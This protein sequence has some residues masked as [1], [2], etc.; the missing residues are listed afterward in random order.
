VLAAHFNRRADGKQALTCFGVGFEQD[1]A[2]ILVGS[3]NVAFVGTVIPAQA[4][5]SVL[6]RDLSKNYARAL[7]QPYG[8][9]GYLLRKFR[10]DTFQTLQIEHLHGF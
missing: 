8:G 4:G 3:G 2:G 1:S 9:P 6:F 5:T 7:C 10:N